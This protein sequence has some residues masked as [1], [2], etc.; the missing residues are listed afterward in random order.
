MQALGPRGPS[1]HPDGA[2]MR[3][4]GGGVG[5]YTQAEGRLGQCKGR[6]DRG[7]GVL[8]DLQIET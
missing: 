8:T 6:G 5:M 7:G 3:G 4:A 2:L 1:P